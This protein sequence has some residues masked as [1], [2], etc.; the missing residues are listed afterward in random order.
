MK[1]AAS[2]V[3]KGLKVIELGTFITGPYTAMLLANLGADVIKV[4]QPQ[5]GDPFRN[6]EGSMYSPQFRAYNMN[7]R[8]VTVNLKNTRG[9]ELM[10]L[11]AATADILIEN[12]RPGVANQLGIGWQQ[13]NSVNQRLIY[14]SITGFGSDGPFIDRPCYDT[15][16]QAL[17]GYLSQFLDPEEPSITGPA[18]ADA[19]SGMFAAYGILGAVHERAQTGRGRRVEVAMLEALIAFAA[20]PF[21]SYFA[22]DEVP[23]PY[24]RPSIS[25][26]YVFRC[27]DK[28][29]IALHLASPDKFWTG[30]TNCIGCSALATDGRFSSRKGRIA[31]FDALTLVLRKKFLQH[32]RDYWLE[33]LPLY[34]VPHAP[35]AS[36]DE[37]PSLEQVQHRKTFQHTQHPTEGKVTFV[38][39]PIVY[40]GEREDSRYPPPTLSE[41][42]DEI[43]QELGYDEAA[44]L[45]LRSEGAI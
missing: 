17:S 1:N 45:D 3:L 19:I 34:D 43:L 28:K 22:T 2:G 20:E 21:A 11:L 8:S 42:T 44:I 30:L 23:T 9:R 33:K 35:V 31:N 37:V 16:A 26:S 5:T 14:C 29:L 15:V 7:K 41:H 24:S 39:S 40:D 38:Q 27:A 36:L 12:F 32:P 25:Q 6:Y 18:V 4:E 10:Y 13:L